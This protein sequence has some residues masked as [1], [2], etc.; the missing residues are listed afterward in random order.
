[1]QPQVHVH[2]QRG[3]RGGSGGARAFHVQERP[4]PLL[5]ERGC[6]DMCVRVCVCKRKRFSTNTE[7]TQP[8][9]LWNRILGKPLLPVP[10]DRAAVVAMASWMVFVAEAALHF[11]RV[12]VDGISFC[13]SCVVLLRFTCNSKTMTC[14]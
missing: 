9:K 6:V 1:M 7:H 10:V 8:M 2:F 5:D 14:S 12:C 3:H 13:R 4:R 11:A